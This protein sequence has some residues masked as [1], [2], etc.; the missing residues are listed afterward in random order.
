MSV[1]P[2]P[3]RTPPSAVAAGGGA[4]PDYPAPMRTSLGLLVS[5]AAL[6][7]WVPAAFAQTPAR[8][9]S[10]IPATLRFSIDPSSTFS[11]S[12]TFDESLQA[13]DK[14]GFIVTFPAEIGR[15]STLTV[16]GP[17]TISAPQM[18]YDFS[19]SGA[20]FNVACSG[21][22]P[23]PAGQP[24]A[25]ASSQS[26]QVLTVQSL[27]DVDQSGQS[28]FG[29][30][31]GTGPEG[32]SF[33]GRGDAASLVGA[34]GPSLPDVLAAKVTLPAGA[35]DK[36]WYRASL[37]SAS[38]ALAQLPTSCGDE[39]GI[40]ADKCQMTL[41]W[42]GEV[43]ITAD[44][45][46]Y[47]LFNFSQAPDCVGPKD[48]Q[49]AQDEVDADR[50]KQ[51]TREK[52]VQAV[53]LKVGSPG[54]RFRNPNDRSPPQAEAAATCA[55][56]A[57][58]DQAIKAQ[59]RSLQQIADDPAD[60]HFTT[61]AMPRVAGAATIARVR[62]VLPQLGAWLLREAQ[63]AA[64]LTA[65]STSMNRASGAAA[66]GASADTSMQQAAFGKDA[67]RAGAL[68]AGERS[69]AAAA[70]RELR[71]L[72]GQPAERLAAMRRLAAEIGGAATLTNGRQLGAALS[73]VG[74]G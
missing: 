16:A 2:C 4:G 9:V 14:L 52:T 33:D 46:H 53:C 67:R 7:A 5:L 12:Q 8:A 63:V 39:Y 58:A 30:C 20:S 48:K 18:T 60:P 64:Q 57:L 41:H 40:A 72:H 28:G 44:S 62:R 66:A 55:G 73:S 51:A 36:G 29:T 3:D 25:T 42:T 37:T 21:S 15:D 61:V 68:L 19:E 32:D 69:L 6:A 65:A 31:Y 59:D 26:P 70:A 45:C 71:G 27:T 47:G 10:A 49:A 11:A 1:G 43:W 54:G 35:L 74:R 23:M 17:G 24:A 50:G 22:V 56:A 38:D 34:F 13:T